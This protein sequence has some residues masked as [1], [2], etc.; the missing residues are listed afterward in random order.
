MHRFPALR[1]AKAALV[2][3][4]SLVW[5]CGQ[6][7]D[8]Y[9][10]ADPNNCLRSTTVCGSGQ[11]CNLK[12]QAC[13]ADPAPYVP[14]DIFPVPTSPPSFLSPGGQMTA[15]TYPRDVSYVLASPVP[16]TIYYTLDGSVPAA[17][18]PGTLSGPS[19]VSLGVLAGGS[20]LSWYA[21]AGAPYS[22]ESVHTFS[23]T[24]DDNM[25]PADYGVISENVFFALSKGPVALVQRGEVVGLRIG[26][27]AWA[28]TAAGTC[29]G[30][31]L[32]YVISLGGVG[33]V[34]CVE[35][36]QKGGAYPGGTY[37]TA[38]YFYAPMTTGRFPIVASVT[39]KASCD[40][41]VGAN[42]TE[43]GELFVH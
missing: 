19:P 38:F 37:I 28:S 39:N 27:Q 29:A 2:L 30:C 10:A 7:W 32:Q 31:N 42:G 26:F 24:T 1:V 43:I 36:I 23:P 11:H 15:L 41:S 34:T 9:S 18:Q 16:A 13:E 3:A 22:P 17:G 35:N 12:T 20:M 25:P 6:L 5:G 21:D 33:P 14:A 4:S 40:G 8:Y